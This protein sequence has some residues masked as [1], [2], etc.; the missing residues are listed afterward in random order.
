VSGRRIDIFPARKDDDGDRR[1]AARIQTKTK[2][3]N[4]I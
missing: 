3:G 1:I 2:F 4:L